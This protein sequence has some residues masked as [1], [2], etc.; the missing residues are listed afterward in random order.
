MFFLGIIFA[1]IIAICAIPQQ[2]FPSLKYPRLTVVT[3]YS[4]AG[5]CDIE[6]LI[7]S[8]LE[9]I[10]SSVNG[11]KE[12]SSISK[13]GISLIF[14]DFTWRTNIN[15]ASLEIRE[16]IDLI[17]EKLPQESEES[18]VLK[19]N[20]FDESLMVISVYTDNKGNLQ[21]YYPT[22]KKYIKEKLEKIEGVA[23]CRIE[24][25]IEK[26]I[27][28][29]VL[30]SKLASSGID[31][32]D[33][34]ESLENGNLNY[35][36]GKVE[37]N[38]FEWMVRTMG[39]F[40]CLDDIKNLPVLK[41][42]IGHYKTETFKNRP[43][44][45]LLKD[46]A[47]INETS[48]KRTGFSRINGQ[49]VISLIIQKQSQANIIK[50]AKK[51]KRSLKGI[52]EKIPK[53]IN[54][55]ITYDQSLF[56]EKAIKNL[57]SAV[58]V[59]GILA[60]LILF[61]FMRQIRNCV[62]VIFSIPV[63]LATA[64]ICMYFFNISFNLIS[65]GGLALGVGMIVDSSI[66]VFENISKK[67]KKSEVWESAWEVIPA[68]SASTFTTIAVFLPTVFIGGIA[69]KFFKDLG[70]TVTFSLI[71]SL[72]VA[73]T[74][75]PSLLGDKKKSATGKN[76]NIPYNENEA[77]RV[78]A[79]GSLDTPL[80]VQRNPDLPINRGGISCR[81]KFQRRY[82]N[83]LTRV[84]K[85]PFFLVVFIIILGGVSFILLKNIDKEFMPKIDKSEITITLDMPLN[86]KLDITNQKTL[87]VESALSKLSSIETIWL[88]VGSSEN[89]TFDSITDL[90]SNQAKFSIKLI[91]NSHLSSDNALIDIKRALS[92]INLAGAKLN[93]FIEK[94]I[95]QGVFDDN[96]QTLT[97]RAKGYNLDG[98]RK[99]SD[100]IKDKL[101][102][103]PFLDN[104]KDDFEKS[105]S[106]EKF[107]ISKE[108]AALYN[109]SA[110]DIAQIGMIALKGWVAT[111]FKK[112][113]EEIDVRV[114]LARANNKN[115]KDIVVYN[116]KGIGARFA[117]IAD[118]KKDT[119]PSRIKHFDKER[120]IT[121][122]AGFKG[123]NLAQAAQLIEEKLSGLNLTE[124]YT[125]EIG[126]ETLKMKESF[127]SLKFALI[128]AVVL[129][130]MIM[131]SQFESLWQPFII[132]F[133]IPFSFAG[134]LI[135]LHLR[136]YSLN[137]IS[138]LGIV[139]LT[140][141]AVNNAIVL[142][143]GIN[144][145]KKN[146][147]LIDA[148]TKA[149]LSRLRPVLMTTL[150]TIM[151]LL[152]LTFNLS[153]NTESYAPLAVT[154]IGGLVV[155]TFLTLIVIPVFYFI[156]ANKLLKET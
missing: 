23:F 141:I 21:D 25:A 66:V 38:F 113:A 30:P 142:I 15:F 33:I 41:R 55:K 134:A 105:S 40:R 107:I 22:I 27:L 78:K 111:K 143:S 115:L 151:G 58:F 125:Y 2:L 84:F 89:D 127:N 12:M 97:I 18:K 155:S 70:L 1:G 131:A 48:K 5:P 114:N 3:K 148:I 92:K 42:Q 100:Q 69:G 144:A 95:L 6:N 126:G 7:T 118:F 45:I 83:F 145:L 51:V 101:F 50:T 156:F 35:P 19:Y 13:E 11:L 135:A 24:G 81:D 139:I 87:L 43:A 119:A 46:L 121:V 16:K 44:L 140:G 76:L 102:E 79:H 39:E 124:G 57:V 106:E 103:I 29:N 146:N 122:S 73:I 10:L 74:L 104:I 53:D 31:L 90:K 75:I 61:A 4:G 37:D 136:H 62:I 47:R 94:N 80:L 98:L 117:D 137:I 112:D 120:A 85:A 9:E 82:T 54:L 153:K 72:L 67:D 14:L 52:T 71:G 154:V 20:P 93:F 8:P 63:S 17:K 116:S 56:I 130:Y 26:E 96:R 123:G 129:V 152:P 60:F 86:T 150:T 32:L 88:R 91:E 36:A 110:A 99:I 132:M 65:L 28:V 133:T 49:E 149:S 147:N 68:I 59:G 64:F 77:S 108:K 128:L 34:T 109:L 138:F